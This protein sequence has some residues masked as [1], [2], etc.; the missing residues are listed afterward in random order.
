[1]EILGFLVIALKEGLTASKETPGWKKVLG[2]IA[3]FIA[4][5]M[6]VFGL[7]VFILM[8]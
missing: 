1:M 6:V 2:A 7:L 3:F 5:A 8:L 4:L